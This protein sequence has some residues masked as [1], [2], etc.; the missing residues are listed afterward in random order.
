MAAETVRAITNPFFPSTLSE[1]SKAVSAGSAYLEQSV[2]ASGHQVFDIDLVKSNNHIHI[3]EEEVIAR[4][5]FCLLRHFKRTPERPDDPKVLIITPCQGHPATLWRDTIQSMLQEHDVYVSEWI[6][7]KLVPLARGKFDWEDCVQY[8]FSFIGALGPNIHVVAIGEAGNAVLSAASLLADSDDPAQP[9]SITFIGCPIDTDAASDN[10]SDIAKSRKIEWFEENFIRV[11]PFFY[12]GAYRAIY[13]GVF[14]LLPPT[15]PNAE[16]DRENFLKSFLNLTRGNDE[17]QDQNMN[18][19]TRD[20]L[21]VIDVPAEYYLQTIQRIYQ[22][23]DLAKNRARWHYRLIKPQSLRHTALLTV[24]SDLDN[25]TPPGQTRAVLDLCSNVKESMKMSYLQIGVGHLALFVGRKW[26]TDV[27]PVVR[28]FI[29]THPHVP[30]QGFIS[31]SGA[32]VP[33]RG[34]FP[35]N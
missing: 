8:A 17:S 35:E 18:F 29:R 31:D 30:E 13:P 28:D 3:V 21:S 26:R 32:F 10:L 9:A 15:H 16:P 11:L 24:E 4:K 23:N 25:V 19:F 20:Y 1:M 14:R 12:P 5:P 33:P 6:D 7:A 34:Q 27:Y 22:G 2:K